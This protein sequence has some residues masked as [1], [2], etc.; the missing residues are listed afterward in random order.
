[1]KLNWMLSTIVFAGAAVLTADVRT[2]FP[3]DPGPLHYS[4]L[5]KN[6]AGELFFAH[7]DEWAAVWFLRDPASVFFVAQPGH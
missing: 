4:Y 1:M 7:E 5:A 3:P 2:A 6:L